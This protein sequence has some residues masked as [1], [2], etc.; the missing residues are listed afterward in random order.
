MLM[1]KL[2]VLTLIS[3][4]SA[5]GATQKKISELDAASTFTTNVYVA[6]IVGDNA[7][8]TNYETMKIAAGL[9]L[10]GF[11]T[12][13]TTLYFY[14]DGGVIKGYSTNIASAQITSLDAAKLT[15]TI[16]TNRYS[17]QV[18]L[19]DQLDS[20]AE[21]EDR[22]GWTLPGAGSGDD[23]HI[24]GSDITNPDFDDDT[25]VKH[26]VTGTNVVTY[27]TN[28][29]N[30]H[31]ASGA[32][33]ARS[34]I[35]GGTASHIVINDGSGDLSSEAT[36]GAT[37]FPALTGDV[38][39][40]GGSLATT[41]ADNAV[42]GTDI[43]LTSEA[44]GDIMYFNGTDWVRLAKGTAGQVL[45]M[46]AGATAPEWDT[47]DTSS[48]GTAGTVI[49]TGTPTQYTFPYYSDTTGTNVAPTTG[50]Y[51]DASKTN[52]YVTGVIYGY[53]SAVGSYYL[54]SSANTNLGV[55][56]TAPAT[57]STNHNIVQA[58]NPYPG[59]VIRTLSA[60]TNLTET[61]TN[62]IA[63]LNA[64]L[65]G[66]TIVG[67][68][69][70]DTLSNKT[71][72]DSSNTILITDYIPFVFPTSVDGTGCTITTNSYISFQSGKAT[73]AGSGSTNANYAF[74]DLGPVPRNL[75]TSTEWILRDLAIR[76]AGTDTDEVTFTIG[77][78]C[79]A[80][81]AAASPTDYTSLSSYISVA[82][83]ALTTPAA[84][85][86]FYIDNVTLTGW[87]AGVTE[88]RRL[89]IGIARLDSTNDD[90]I[91]IGGGQIQI[92]RTF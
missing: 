54:G 39:S 41:I 81:S 42:D 48:G 73:Y 20:Q 75:S 40:A 67:D 13:N 53:S 37:R 11:L 47:D 6:S 77:F 33:I 9:L 28:L 64:Q 92:K 65:T 25:Y 7:T 90:S 82:S 15:G 21:F 23:V 16:D 49:N 87:A 10:Y 44:A 26:V 36:L 14:M 31:I 50:I 19:K 29:V 60:V 43:S 85:D 45:E 55:R 2:I 3:A 71:I 88:G 62:T 4:I 89:V 83:G 32:A 35:A 52:L 17:S 12:N 84:G 57:V 74:F 24:N 27:V 59:I 18:L 34:K 22:L 1:K 51:T 5:F 68:S 8:S 91:V 70:T 66:A 78:F 79:P 30:A 58:E 86:G 72:D 63:G 76:V 61:A 56:Y 80:S 46:N 38:T 69:T